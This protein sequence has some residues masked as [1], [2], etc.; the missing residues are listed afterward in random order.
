MSTT[1]KITG[2]FIALFAMQIAN[3]LL[4][5]LTI[6]YLGIVLGAEGF[7]LVMFS[8]AF[9]QYFVLLTDFGFNL[10]A[11]R[12]IS[13]YREHS[14]KVSEI[15]SAVYLIKVVLLVISFIILLVM[16]FFIDKFHEH[17]YVYILNF[18]VVIGQVLFPVWLFQGM[19]KMKY[20][21]ILNIVAKSIFTVLIFI[22]VKSQEELYYVPLLNSLGFVVAGGIGFYIAIRQF[23]LRLAFPQKAIIR[24]SLRESGQF[25]ISRISVSAY[26]ISNTFLIGIFLGN[27]AVG[28]FS[29]AEKICNVISTGVSTIVDAIYPHMARNKDIKIFKKI[30]LGVMVISTVGSIGAFMMSDFIINLL[31]GSNYGVSV[32]ILKIMIIAAYISI[33]SML[34]GYPLLAAFG[35]LNYANYS[36]LIASIFHILSLLIIAPSGN[37]YYITAILIL[38]QFIVLIIRLYGCKKKLNG[39]IFENSR[40]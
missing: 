38:T 6:P 1:K 17:M 15:V 40:L 29:A 2:N 11:T 19:E 28:Y 30:F 18:G 16:T 26:T 4:P 7:G 10:S 34:I 24:E 21:T 36:V 31:F 25:F 33:P 22:I 20:T 27:T 35:Y 9:I 8:Q 5:L 37:I 3:F 32:G 12:K 23:N 39:V 14:D 13:V